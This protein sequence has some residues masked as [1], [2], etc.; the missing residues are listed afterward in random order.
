MDQVQA[1]HRGRRAENRRWNT[2]YTKT[3]S[4]RFVSC[5]RNCALAARHYGGSG[6]GEKRGATDH[7]PRSAATRRVGDDIS[8]LSARTLP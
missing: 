1:K 8:E 5:N 2:R 3:E 6:D 4:A 7:R